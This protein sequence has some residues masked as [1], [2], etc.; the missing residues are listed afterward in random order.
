MVQNDCKSPALIMMV[1]PCLLQRCS[2]CPSPALQ[3]EE[4]EEEAHREIELSGIR[5]VMQLASLD[6][7]IPLSMLR[8][9]SDPASPAAMRSSLD[10][11]VQQ[12]MLSSQ[13]PLLSEQ[14]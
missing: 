5:P 6:A 1:L 3:I 11:G 10:A 8:L 14:N 2:D 13:D 9:P 4:V 7:K 12:N